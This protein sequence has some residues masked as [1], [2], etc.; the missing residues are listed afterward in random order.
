MNLRNIVQNDLI[1][2]RELMF[3]MPVSVFQCPDT[4]SRNRILRCQRRF[5][6]N[7]LVF[8]A[9]LWEVRLTYKLEYVIVG[10]A[11]VILLHSI[12]TIGTICIDLYWAE[13][14]LFNYG[15]RSTVSLV[16]FP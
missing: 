2:L 10:P 13:Q 6:R 8:Q 5:V 3:T 1:A 9:I 16:V 15:Q 11:I 4:S 12:F 7:N 14:L